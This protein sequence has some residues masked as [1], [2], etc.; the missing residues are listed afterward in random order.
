MRIVGYSEV[1]PLLS[2]RPSSDACRAPKPEDRAMIRWFTVCCLLAVLCCRFAA[3]SG[4]RA[5][6]NATDEPLG[7]DQRIGE[8]IAELGS[9]D[10]ARREKAQAELER[11]SMMAFDALRAAEN[12]EDIEIALR[13]RYLVRRMQVRWYTEQDSA[14]VRRVLRDYGSQSETE[15][16]SRMERLAVLE[17][18]QGLQALARLVRFEAEVR[19][20]RHAALLIMKQAAVDDAALRQAR[21]DMLRE[22][23]SLSKRPP[24]QWVR[25]YAQS[26]V[27]PPAADPQWAEIVAEE[28]RVFANFPEQTSPEILIDLLHWRADQLL[29]QQRRDEAMPLVLSSLDLTSG[30]REQLQSLLDWLMDREI[31]EQIDPLAQRFPEPFT[32]SLLLRYRLAEAY[33]RQGRSELAE[34][35]AQAALAAHPE[36]YDE[37]I[38][39]AFAQQSR[40]LFAWA[41]QEYRY[42]ISGSG[43]GSTHGLRARLFLAEMLHDQQRDLGAGEVLQE[44]VDLIGKNP[45]FANRVRMMRTDVD[46][47]PARMHFFFAEHFK[48]SDRQKQKEHLQKGV[49]VFPREI[50][51][52]IAMHHFP[53]ADEQWRQTTQ[54]HIQD[55]VGHY[56]EQIR[57]FND[58]LQQ[59]TNQT[60]EDDLRALLARFNNQLA[61]LLANTDGDLDEALRCSR[62][63]L[64][65]RPGESSYLDTLGRCYY[66]RQEYEN[67]VKYQSRA[68]ALEPHSGQIGRQLKLFQEALAQHQ[69]TPGNG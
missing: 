9:D 1:R 17:D 47:I 42:V 48:N 58:S 37:H 39:V 35:T 25:T 7:L 61:W 41:E 44:L 24:S 34:T 38:E 68:A 33:A 15:R 23:I 56:R 6:E 30:R 12:H 63:S 31:W 67:A 54:Q 16:R 2:G 57:R 46:D 66:A 62:L 36:Q 55:T 32:D 26:L 19:L 21:A 43:E 13:A 40:G 51:V 14:E 60:Y 69:Q 50:D 28:Q 64:E 52:L 49:Q 11:L 59:N 8:L 27:D 10:F 5:D 20:A 29:R 65:Y 45:E 18:G 3:P 53:E 4:L 22:A